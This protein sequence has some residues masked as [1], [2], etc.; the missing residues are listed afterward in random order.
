MAKR[1]LIADPSDALTDTLLGDENAKEYEIKVVRNGRECLHTISEFSPDLILVELM[2]PLMHG[3]EVLSHVREND[4]KTGVIISSY[5]SMVQN[6]HSAIE[7]GADYFLEKPYSPTY[8]FKLVHSFFKGELKPKPFTGV[9]GKPSDSDSCYI[10]ATYLTDHY[11]R[12]W[13]TRG[14]NPVSGPDY[15]RYGGNTCCLE[16]RRGKDLIIIDAGTGIRPLGNSLMEEEFDTIHIFIGHT[17]WDH[18][19]GFPFFSPLYKKNMSIIVYAPVGFEKN[20]KQLFTDMTAYSFFPVRLDEMQSKLTFKELRND[21]PYQIGDVTLET[22]YTYHPGPTFGFK[23][24]TPEK[25]FGYVTDNEMLLGYQ[26]HPKDI[27][28]DH[29]LLQPHWDIINFLKG[30]DFLIHEAQYLPIEYHLKIGWGHSSVTN[31]SV[32]IKYAG[33]TEWIITHHDP[34]H[35]DR[36]LENKLRLHQKILQDAEVFCYTSLAFDGLI[37]P[38]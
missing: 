32:L 2:L 36:D 15:V 26:G 8:F 7:G 6:Y 33:I 12:F 38:I 20:T 19:T 16:I 5:Q 11:I 18:I 34:K 35:T 24:T 14:S 30:V 23:I 10:P 31:A 29:A 21:K 28:E 37:L 27:R 22:H 4:S 25:K 9:H 13:G 17:H 1:I 3:I